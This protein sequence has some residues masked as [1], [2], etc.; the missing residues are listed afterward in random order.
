[1]ARQP[2]NLRPGPLR[3]VVIMRLTTLHKASAHDEGVWSSTWVP[4][5]NK[6]LT[7]SVDEMVKVWEDTADGLKF[8]HS[9]QGHTLGVVSVATNSTGEYAASSALDSYIRVWSLKDHSTAAMIEAA[10]TESWSIAF[11][12]EQAGDA[13]SLLLAVAGG[14]RGSVVVWSINKEESAALKAELML[15]QVCGVV[16]GAWQPAWRVPHQ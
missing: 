2:I 3:R 16:G 11:S 13:G 7:G 12:P 15:P 5:T 10:T 14:T 4:G 8:V 1:M 6:L 9:Y